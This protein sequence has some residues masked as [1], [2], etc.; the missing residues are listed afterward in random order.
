MET[1]KDNPNDIPKRDINP[2]NDEVIPL[3]NTR[4]EIRDKH[5]FIIPKNHLISNVI[6]NV[7]ERV[8]TRR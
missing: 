8:V 2:N 3:H 5:K 6:G 7:N 4:E 1:T